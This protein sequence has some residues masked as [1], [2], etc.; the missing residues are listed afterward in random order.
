MSYR[1][2]GRHLDAAARH[3]PRSR[4]YPA[5]RSPLRTVLHPRGPVLDQ[6]QQS[7]CTGHATA[8]ALN[9]QPIRRTRRYLT[10]DDAVALYCVA[11]QID[12]FPGTFPPEDT[13]SDGLSVAKAAAR[14]RYITSYQH[15]FGLDHVLG[16]LVN[17]PVIVGTAWHAAMSDPDAAG[18]VHPSGDVEGGHEWCLIGL[19]V[20]HQ[21]VTAQ[22]SWGEA[23]GPLG[24]LFRVSFAD[25]GAL[26]A[27]GGDAT[28]LVR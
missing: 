13:G 7:S 15:A 17:G 28:V 25:L 1:P 9:C 5:G 10:H 24:G 21:Y 16:A 11:T 23:W 19:D 12:P 6:G 14:K 18:F 2:L 26:L 8:A 20:E 3:D 4:A 22:Q 27:D